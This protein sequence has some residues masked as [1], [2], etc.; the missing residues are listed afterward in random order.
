MVLW[1]TVIR[2]CTTVKFERGHNPDYYDY[3]SGFIPTVHRPEG[4]VLRCLSR[5][6][7]GY[8]PFILL[9]ILMFVEFAQ[10]CPQRFNNK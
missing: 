3:R 10:S 4:Q 2:M 7:V 5:F 1:T 6:I 9:I 8:T